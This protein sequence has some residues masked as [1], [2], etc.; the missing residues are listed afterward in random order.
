[1]ASIY[2]A[3]ISADTCRPKGHARNTSASRTIMRRVAA[4]RAPMLLVE[5]M[6]A[7]IS[8]DYFGADI[9]QGYVNAD[10]CTRATEAVGGLAPGLRV[11]NLVDA[12]SDA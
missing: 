3:I 12:W 6:M 1:M 11:R 4:G 8:A 5:L 2:L 9:F 7:P 10:V